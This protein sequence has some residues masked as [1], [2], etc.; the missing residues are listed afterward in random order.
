[1]VVKHVD[2]HGG[3][4]HAARRSA[5]TVN[6]DILDCSA[7]INPLGPSPKVLQALKQHAREIIHYPDP[8]SYELCQAL[9]DRFQVKRGEI[10]VGNG[11]NE[12]IYHLPLAL[13]ITRALVIGPTYSEYA[14]AV[15]CHGGAV[16]WVHAK[17]VSDYAPPFE[18]MLR[19][20]G[21]KKRR[22]NEPQALF[23]CNPNSPTG[24]VL[25]QE[26]IIILVQLAV[27]KNI[28]VILDEAFMDYC[29]ESSLTPLVGRYENLLVLRSFTKFYAVPGLRLGM[30]LASSR[31]V[32]RVRA[33]LPTWSVN[34]LAQVAGLTALQDKKF[35]TRSLKVIERERVFMI[36][37]L[38]AL[39]G[40]HVYSSAANFLMMQLPSYCRATWLTRTLKIKGILI[41]DLSLVPGLSYRMIRIGIRTR[42]ENV[43][44]LHHLRRDITMS[45]A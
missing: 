35:S 20:L 36:Q 44:V 2:R 40:C 3:N 34:I 32:D 11:S 1:M 43:R 25:S 26:Q 7:S 21:S 24:Q 10:I 14:K 16:T 41:R 5:S 29:E 15:M 42:K 28:H 17:E 8:D 12:L 39:E 31:V 38:R 45:R 13:G 30:L 4:I 9:A 27:K 22:K 19:F 37:A 23:L 33:V 18:K 6:L